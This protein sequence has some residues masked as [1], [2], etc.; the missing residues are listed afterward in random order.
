VTRIISGE[1]GSIALDTPRGPTRPTSD[2]VREA[3]FSTIEN[4]HDL[5]DARVLDLYAGSG[6][7]GL[8]AVSRGARSVVLVDTSAQAV[9][10][11]KSNARKIS[12]ALSREVVCDVVRQS[13]DHYCS[14]LAGDVFFDLVLIDP[15]YDVA[16]DEVCHLMELISPHLSDTG[17]VVI[18]RSKKTPEPSWPDSVE[19]IKAKTYGDTAVYFVSPKR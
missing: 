19:L 7:L 8:E 11:M 10:T 18:E 1:A 14:R 16:N 6:A 12:R 9:T 5:T 2:R 15:P 13:A 3:M 17:V 4:L